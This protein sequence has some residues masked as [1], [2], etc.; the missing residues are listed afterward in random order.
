MQAGQQRLL[1]V[2]ADDFGIGPDTSA[3]ILH[4][5]RRGIVTGSVLLVNSPYAEASVRSW[6]Q[7]DCPMELGWHP[8]LTLDAPVLPAQCVPSLVGHDGLF[9]PLGPFLKRWLLGRLVCAEIEAEFD[10][11]LQRF[12]ELVGQPPSLVNTHQHVGLFAPIGAA[13]LRVLQR[14]HCRPYVRRVQEPLR[15]LRYI[16]GARIK[17]LVLNHLGRDIARLQTH[18]SFPGND[19]LAGITDPC[20]V[21]DSQFFARWLHALPGDRVEFMC[22]PGYYDPTLIGRDCRE[23][24]GLLQR[25]VDE[26]ALLEQPHF[27]A[28]VRAAGFTLVPPAHF[29]GARPYHGRAA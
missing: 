2:V 4:M 7:Y 27:L 9:W 25:R 26:L 23:N 22:H 10:A 18:L 19:C 1:A 24:D 13:L 28:A 3:G 5:A 12:R 8:N 20:W 21:K 6:R 16:P 14:R 29:L 15:T 11:Q 17:R